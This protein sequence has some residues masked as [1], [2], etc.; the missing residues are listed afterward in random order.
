MRRTR[1]LLVFGLLVLAC[2]CFTTCNWENPV[3]K[4]W[5]VEEEPDYEYIP[6][7]KN[8]PIPE[9]TYQTIIESVEVWKTIPPEKVL[10]SIEIIGIDYIIF[11]GNSDTFNGDPVPATGT[12]LTPQ[13]MEYNT[14]TIEGVATMLKDNPDYLVL[15]H[16][17][18][19]PTTFTDGETVELMQLSQDRADAVAAELETEY[20]KPSVANEPLD[21]SRMSVS[22]YG[23]EKILFG[24]NS[25]YTSLNRRVEVILF[26]IKTTS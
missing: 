23:G 18:A 25:P 13:E 22:G 24:N 11:A 17:H 5:W 1:A 2:A 21:Q 3:M 15:L 9:I 20:E 19:N 26:R 16:G 6:I 10:Q 4:K 12:H 8:I 7:L 14:S